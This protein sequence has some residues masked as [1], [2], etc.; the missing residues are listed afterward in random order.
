MLSHDNMVHEHFQFPLALG[1]GLAAIVIL[2]MAIVFAIVC[3]RPL[4]QTAMLV[5]AV[6][7]L[8]PLPCALDSQH[9][10]QLGKDLAGIL[11]KQI[12]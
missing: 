11:V 12:A 2:V 6:V 3:R 9:L 4:W 7:Q 8:V 5:H 1:T 10:T